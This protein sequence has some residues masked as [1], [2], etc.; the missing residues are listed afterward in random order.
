[1]RCKNRDG[2]AAVGAAGAAG[3]AGAVVQAPILGFDWIT[4]FVRC[5]IRNILTH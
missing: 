5:L 2:A 4:G 3:A 1:M